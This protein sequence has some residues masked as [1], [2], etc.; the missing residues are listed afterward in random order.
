MV[1]C[2]GPITLGTRQ[3][4]EVKVSD[5]TGWA[6]VQVWE[7]NIGL[8]VEGHW[9]KLKRFRIVAYENVKSSATCWQGSETLSIEELEN[10]VDPTSKCSCYWRRLYHFAQPNDC[11]FVQA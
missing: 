5:A 4:Q 7:D 1:S 8:L 9:Y 11:H 3:K 10:A 2:G 6:V